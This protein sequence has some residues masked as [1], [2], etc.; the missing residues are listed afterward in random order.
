MSILWFIAKMCPSKHGEGDNGTRQP[1]DLFFSK[2][3]KLVCSAR[4]RKP[5]YPDY[6]E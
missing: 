6:F 4:W 3:V 5:S 1:S 2:S